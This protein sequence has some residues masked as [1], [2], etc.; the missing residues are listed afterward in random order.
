MIT[1]IDYGLG[2]IR[3]LMNWF[4]REALEVVLSR[5]PGVIASSEMLILPGVGAYGDAMKMLKTYGLDDIIRKEAQEGKPLVGICL[6]MQLLYDASYEG[7][8]KKGLGLLLGDIKPFKTTNVKVPH[9]GWNNL[10]STKESL[11]QTYV[12]FVHS[13]YAESGGEEVI[14]Y[15]E[16]DVKVPS[17]V[18]KDN[19]LGFQFHPEKS[20][21]AGK[22]MMDMIKELLDDNI[23]SN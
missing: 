2:N 13:F 8:Y 3:S 4:K 19:I 5:D 21:D 23:S 7:G 18:K 12:Y 11:N 6:G 17:V 14:A 15:A 1:I 9:M 20:G 16:Y 22:L 10:L